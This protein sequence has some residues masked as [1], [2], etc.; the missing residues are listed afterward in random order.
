MAAALSLFH[1]ETSACGTTER[2]LERLGA[3][4]RP[5]LEQKGRVLLFSCVSS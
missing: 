2:R 5:I 4:P 3:I 1:L